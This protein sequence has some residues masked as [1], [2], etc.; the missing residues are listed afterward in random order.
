MAILKEKEKR[1][2]D[3]CKEWWEHKQLSKKLEKEK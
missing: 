1:E 2:K 3:R